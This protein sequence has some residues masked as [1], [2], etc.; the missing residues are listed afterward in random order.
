MLERYEAELRRLL[1][2]Q[3]PPDPQSLRGLYKPSFHRECLVDVT[4]D[5]LRIATPSRSIWA[6]VNRQTTGPG[7]DAWIEPAIAQERVPLEADEWPHL[8]AA[9]ARLDLVPS[10]AAGAMIDGMPVRVGRGS[11]ELEQNVGARKHHDGVV[12]FAATLLRFAEERARWNASRSAL[13]ELWAYLPA[14]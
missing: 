3:D 11:E 13:G 8:Q 14:G 5:E 6:W 12:V 4:R 1:K 9:L 10:P 7:S 2:I